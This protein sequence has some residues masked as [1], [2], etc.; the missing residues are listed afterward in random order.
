MAIWLW[1]KILTEEKL[2]CTEIKLPNFAVMRNV[3]LLLLCCISFSCMAKKTVRTYADSIAQHREK[4]KNEFLTDAH[5]PLKA[6]DTGNL[7]FF[8]PDARYRVTATFKLTPDAPVFD[9]TTHSGKLKKYR[10]YGIISFRIHDTVQTL[11]VYQGIDLMK[12]PEL[13]DYLFIPF[14]DLTNYETTYGGG[15]YL[16]LRTGDI[17]HNTVV[18]DFN[19][20]YNPYCAYAGGY[21]CPIPPDANKLKVTI[22]AGEMQYAGVVKE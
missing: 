22:P 18:I 12:Q 7:R 10:R 19:K 16:D 21:S 8:A 2:N 17:K 9:M 20:C 1:S 13:K 14:T 4:Y 5:S 11:E 15:R 6:T 3:F